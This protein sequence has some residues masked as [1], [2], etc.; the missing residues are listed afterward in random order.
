M[1]VRPAYVADQFY[2]GDPD[3]LRAM[4]TGYI[5][6]APVAARPDNVSGVIVPHAGYIFSG[7]TAGYG[8]K[9]I[10][11][12]VPDRV[13]LLGVSH[14]YRFD[15]P[16]LYGGEAFDSP[17]GRLPL[18]EAFTSSLKERFSWYDGRPHEHE[19]T[20]ETQLPFI[21]LALGA[22]P[23]V[24]I[25]FG[26]PA[27]QQHSDF[28]VQL[29]SMLTPKDLV[30]ASTDLSHFLSDDEAN[31]IDK[32][33]I[34]HILDGDSEALIEELRDERCSACGGAAVIAALSCAAARGAM[35]RRLL[36]YRTSAPVSGDYSRVVGYAAISLEYDE[37]DA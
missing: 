14:R 16:S 24:P 4:A 23:I 31:T 22:T 13:V 17:I 7:A 35:F 12:A 1:N 32:R 27:G 10:Q 30:I 2:P 36:D 33:T 3:E 8:Y 19:H 5:D 9:R 18:D 28:G 26:A 11:G 25:L 29:A 37:E 21:F 34:A 6:A 20:L 15:G